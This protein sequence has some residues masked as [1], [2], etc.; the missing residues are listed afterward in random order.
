CK[1]GYVYLMAGGVG[2]NRFWADTTQWLIDEGLERAEELKEPCW[3]DNDYLAS[4][5]AKTRFTEI[6]STFAQAHTKAQMQEKGRARRI[7]IAPICDTSDLNKSEQRKYREYFIDVTA[8]D[9]SPLV[10]PG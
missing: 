9:G 1:D 4:S 7:P 10:M 3:H 2:G 6:F 8:S 5:L